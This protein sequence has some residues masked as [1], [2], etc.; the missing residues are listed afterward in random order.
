MLT[1]YI[2]VDTTSVPKQPRTN[3]KIGKIFRQ[4]TGEGWRIEFE[5]GNGRVDVLSATRAIRKQ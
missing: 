5:I 2:R 4:I 1:R 3:E